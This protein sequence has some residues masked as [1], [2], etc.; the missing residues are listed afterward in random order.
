MPNM[1][2]GVAAEHEAQRM[3][4]TP[5]TPPIDEG[6]REMRRPLSD[7][8]C[9]VSESLA[10]CRAQ[11]DLLD[12]MRPLHSDRDE[13]QMALATQ[14]RRLRR[15]LDDLSATIES[16][17]PLPDDLSETLER[18]SRAITSLVSTNIGLRSRNGS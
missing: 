6:L 15:I 14:R 5:P 3:L 10:L 1:L 13:M 2:R 9:A 17:V 12:E 18:T 16:Q 11:L 7:I 8:R 4:N